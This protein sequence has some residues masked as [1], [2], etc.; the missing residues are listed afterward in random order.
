MPGRFIPNLA[1]A[2]LALSTPPTSLPQ[3]F[4]SQETLVYNIQWR[5]ID[6]GDAR[7]TQDP[8]RSKLHLESS[9]LVSKLYKLDDTYD[10]EM[11]GD[12]CAVSTTLDALDRSRHRE[13]KVIYDYSRGKAN[14][15]ERDL[16]KNSVLKTAEV[17]IPACTHDIIGA[18]YKLRTL[19]LEPGQS[20]TMALSDGK[21]SVSARIEAQ[22]KEEVKIRAGIFNTTR[23]EAF[24]FGGALYTRKAQLLIWISDDP[25]RLPVQIR[26]RLS[27]PIGTVNLELVK[28]DHS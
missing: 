17:E 3:S 2:C 24:V 7:L 23:Y 19:K 15:A 20:T 12:F 22:Q 14:Y 13:T 10:L 18:L 26:L 8:K 5:L 28:E 25:R 4:P 9:G 1:C 6:A 21:K 11:Q 27:F 16:L